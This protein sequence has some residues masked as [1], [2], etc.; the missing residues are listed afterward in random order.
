MV[1][2]QS[3]FAK[4]HLGAHCFFSRK[5]AVRAVSNAIGYLSVNL[6]VVAATVN[7]CKNRPHLI[8]DLVQ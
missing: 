5:N 2:Q 4:E 8:P 1:W 3:C 6:S 7:F